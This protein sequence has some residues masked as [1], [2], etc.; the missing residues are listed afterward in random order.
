M[1]NGLF[2]FSTETKTFGL[3]KRNQKKKPP[4]SFYIPLKGK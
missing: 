2:E 3:Y 4:T 1:M